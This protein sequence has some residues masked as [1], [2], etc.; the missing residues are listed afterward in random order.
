VY[1]LTTATA[2]GAPCGDTLD[3]GAID[4]RH[5]QRDV[6]RLQA[7][8]VQAVKE[9]RWRAVRS[10]QRLLVRCTAAKALAVRQVTNNRGKHTAG[11]DGV[12]WRTPQAKA[13]A[14]ATLG[15]G[16]YKPMPLRRVYI[17]KSSGNT[18]RPLGIPTMFDRAL[19]ALH[20]MA[21]APVS[22]T[23]LEPHACGFR[24]ERST[25][26]A[27]SR[28]FNLLS[29]RGSARWVLEGDIRSCFDNISHEWLVAHV[30]MNKGILRKWLKSGVIEGQT[31]LPTHEGTPQGGVISPTLM[32]L[33]LNGLE[34]A[35]RVQ[36]PARRRQAMK[37]QVYLVSY[38]DD[39]VV[40][41]ASKALLEQHVMPIVERFLGERGLQLSASKTQVTKIEDGFD[42]LGQNIRKYANG[43]LLIK[44]SSKSQ[45]AFR[46]K[47]S[48]ILSRF[49]TAPQ[50]VVIRALN[51]VIRGW[52][53]Y[54]RHVVS[55]D[56]FGRMD[57]WLWLKL[58]RW[59][60]RRHPNKSGRWI[61]GR[62]FHSVGLRNWV[63]RCVAIDARG[64]GVE[65]RLLAMADTRIRRHR[66]LQGDAN[67]YDPQWSSYFDAR[68]QRWMMDHRRS[69]L[70]I[71][72]RRQSGHCACCHHSMTRLTGWRLRRRLSRAKGGADTLDNL[73]LIHPDCS[74]LLDH[75]TGG[76]STTSLSL[77][78]A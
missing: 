57:H 63:F 55:K 17:P 7:R 73:V 68:F 78:Q 19:Q 66:R 33:T 70:R 44:P 65:H 24:W 67:P 45:K 72:W 58:W 49:R 8:L 48:D 60:S 18:M 15:R 39:F 3:W 59:A 35:L 37:H 13:N 53:N 38:A 4:W 27:I 23:I 50:A 32:N 74:G 20:L 42:F 46:S 10:L 41:G 31:L 28:C 2:S 16:G 54:H 12:V 21:L 56:V 29:Q 75:N 61:K 62:Y 25:A 26:D 47:I 51:P 77:T 76:L 30:P 69:A 6:R 40:T 5:C 43:K 36:F 52:A 14:I 11:V 22:E 1:A 71:L 64:R 34:E 9:Q